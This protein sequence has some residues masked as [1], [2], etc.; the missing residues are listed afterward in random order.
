[1]Y[2]KNTSGFNPYIGLKAIC[3]LL[4]AISLFSGLACKTK[5]QIYLYELLRKE[6]V[7]MYDEAMLVACLQ[8][9]ANR[10][11]PVVYVI[12]DD[13]TQ[14]GYWLK[15][16]SSG[17]GWLRHTKA[18][19][20][21]SMDELFEMVRSRITGAVIWDTNVPATINVATTIAGVENAVVLSP[22]FA[23]KYLEKWGLPVVRDL[24]GMFTGKESGSAKNDAYRW[25]I[26]N[27]LSKGR[28]YM[29]RVFLSE[30]AY[31]TRA[32]GDI[33]YVVTRDWAIHKGSFVFDLSPWGDEHP[34]DDPEQP[35]GTDLE[36]YKMML[37]EI[38]RQTDGKEM[39][40]I[41]GFFPFSKYSN[42]PDHP[43]RHEAV[44]TEWESV[45]LM[46]PY[47]CYQNTSTSYCFNQSFHSQAPVKKLKQHRPSKEMKLESKT[48]ICILMADYDSA[49]P[50]YDFLQKSWDDPQRGKMPF[51]WGINPNLIETYPDIIAYFYNTTSEND[52]FGADAS[53][54]GYINPNRILPQYL[55]LFTRHNQKFFNQLDLTIAPMVLDWDEPT[56]QVKDAYA[57]F[58]PDG[59]ATIIYDF[60]TQTVK[61]QKPEVWKGMPVMDLHNHA[62]EF[63]SVGEA[64]KAMSG[65]IPTGEPTPA[66]HFF[67]I[68]WTS[69][70]NVIAGI[71]EL[72]RIR[73]DL[74]I[75][76]TDPYNFFKLFKEY[77]GNK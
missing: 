39:T 58:S 17:N 61:H 43:S 5:T 41:A 40:E 54:A 52:Y 29:H 26:K 6:N 59:F 21:K 64:A 56:D 75:E 25:A 73:P 53:A 62:N 1:M 44:P 57:Q 45:F 16:F 47:N 51:I 32:K 38:L 12:S 77:Y 2:I 68:V 37:S 71:E 28:C 36:T 49:T 35:L 63:K 24:R 18:D 42:M 19:T 70:S 10:Q 30:D 72:K 13:N 23:E 66:F 60:H 15:K 27:Y 20:L 33:G 3:A 34:Q 31:S 11:K 7:E 74:D 65:A 4:I 76:V 48:Y 46:S 69:P 67:R 14:P 50:L 8:G 9:I 22:E 55:P